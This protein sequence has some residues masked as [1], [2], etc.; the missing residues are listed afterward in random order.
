M[1]LG[2]RKAR[3]KTALISACVGLDMDVNDFS[4]IDKFRIWL[5]K[6]VDD[7]MDDKN[8]VEIMRALAQLRVDVPEHCNCRECGTD[9]D[10]IHLNHDFWNTMIWIIL[11][12]AILIPEL[13]R[14]LQNDVAQE[15]VPEVSRIVPKAHGQRLLDHFLKKRPN[16]DWVIPP[17]RKARPDDDGF[18]MD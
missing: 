5:I 4:Q 18:R 6:F 1:D 14:I 2:L 3:I 15:D 10:W 13:R 9:S 7:I 16:P 11:K 17:L 12:V 8:P